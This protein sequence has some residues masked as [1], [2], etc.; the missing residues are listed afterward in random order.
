MPID[1]SY[2]AVETSSN[3]LSKRFPGINIHGIVADLNHQLEV[4]PNNR[5]KIIC[6]LGSTIG[7]FTMSEAKDFLIRLADIMNPEDLLLAGFDLVKGKEIIENAYNDSK[8][9]TEQF[10][11]NIL[12]VVN[13]IIGTD[14]DSD[15]FDHVAFYNEELSRIEMN[16]RANKDVDISS[17]FFDSTINIKMGESIQT[18]ISNKFTIKDIDYLSQSSELEIRN[19][20]KD[21]NEWFAVVEFF[22]NR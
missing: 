17:S 3:I 22:K 13:G 18:E 6:F 2:A 14:F 16:L 21:E 19:I 12:D 4:I 20:F 15:S 7:N 5:K 8:K 10:N 11:K 1:V 9:I